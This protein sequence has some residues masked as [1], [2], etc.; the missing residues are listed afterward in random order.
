[1][2]APVKIQPDESVSQ[3]T[4]V[5]EYFQ[6][7]SAADIY[8]SISPGN[9]EVLSSVILATTRSATG[10]TMHTLLRFDLTGV[11]LGPGEKAVL[12]LYVRPSAFGSAA[13]SPSYPASL[14]VYAGS[15]PWTES[16]T[17]QT[18]PLPTGDKVG[19]VQ[20]TGTNQFI[21][22]D[23]TTQVQAWLSGTANNGFIVQQDTVV[24]D[25]NGRGPGVPGEV[26]VFFRGAGWSDPSQRPYLQVIPEPTSLAAGLAGL[27]VRIIRRKRMIS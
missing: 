11:S 13:P 16:V 27:V 22:F 24:V 19:S 1:L 2:A 23:V 15:T 4:F 14:S 26:G 8:E 12:G 25:P 5:Y 7:S 9:G 18:Q 10:H 17:W 6:S 21:E 20:V 3:D